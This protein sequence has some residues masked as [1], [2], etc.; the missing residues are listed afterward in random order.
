MTDHEHA[1]TGP[2][3]GSG[4]R[5]PQGA[6]PQDAAPAADAGAAG[7]GAAGG[8][9]AAGPTHRFRRDRRHKSLA[10]CAPASDGSA[11]WTR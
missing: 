1:A 4:P 7:P 3:P 5:P 10:E 11:T 2:G 9:D 8:T 6:G